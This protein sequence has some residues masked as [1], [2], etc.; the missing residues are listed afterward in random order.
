MSRFREHR[1]GLSD[2]LDTTINVANR[3]ELVD[4][5]QRTLGC[6]GL[7]I[8]PEDVEIAP[9]GYDSRINWDAHIVTVKDYG[10]FG[11]TDGP[12]EKGEPKPSR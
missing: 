2:S 1:G 4:Y 5:I 6:W 7:D 12:L 11:F 3:G 8:N 9:Y 10:V